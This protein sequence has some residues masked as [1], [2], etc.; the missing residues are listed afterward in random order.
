MRNYESMII[1][2]PTLEAEAID[3][4]IARISD[5]IVKNGGKVEN[6]NKWGKRR[7]AYK[8]GQNNEGYYIVINLQGENET[9]AELD[10]ILKITDEVI[11]HNVIRLG[12]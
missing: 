6:V 3:N 1:L 4:L 9:V 12:K 7:L 10:R 8:I 2:D 11:R 5:V